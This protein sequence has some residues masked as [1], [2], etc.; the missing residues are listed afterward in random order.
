MFSGVRE[1]V[2]WNESGT[3]GWSV[4]CKQILRIPATYWT[5]M[6][7]CLILTTD[8]KVQRPHVE[9]SVK[10]SFSNL[11]SHKVKNGALKLPRFATLLLL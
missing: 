10:E 7:L 5:L 3:N 11:L 2:H 4:K 9:E 8:Y 6:L 1:R